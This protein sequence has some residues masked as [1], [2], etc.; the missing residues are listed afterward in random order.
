MK[1]LIYLMSFLFIIT[2][3]GCD[4]AK[5]TKVDATATQEAAKVEKDNFK[6]N[7]N[8]CKKKCE[9]KEGCKEGKSCK[10]KCAKNEEK[11]K[12]YKQCESTDDCVKTKNAMKKHK[13][14]EGKC[15]GNNLKEE[16]KKETD[17]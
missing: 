5:N 11:C 12:E 13:C 8:C 9:N 3:V 1:Y 4:N 10:H 2:F 16:I 14:S 17:N 7:S 15:G 6:K